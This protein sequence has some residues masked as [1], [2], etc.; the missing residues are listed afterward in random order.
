M[1]TLRIL[2]KLG[3]QNDNIQ[4]FAFK[5]RESNT[6]FMLDWFFELFDKNNKKDSV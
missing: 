5:T 4:L 1:A 6:V 2:K 3:W